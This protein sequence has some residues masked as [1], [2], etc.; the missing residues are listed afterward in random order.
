MV[1]GVVVKVSQD[2]GEVR[3]G[4]CAFATCWLSSRFEAPL[5]GTLDEF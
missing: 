3:D 5:E 2:V 4:K 1:S